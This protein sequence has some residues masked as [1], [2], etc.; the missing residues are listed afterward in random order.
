MLALVA[1]L[2]LMPSV[3]SAH[4]PIIIDDS[5]TTPE[6]GPL[7]LDGTISF[8]LYGVLGGG[9]DTRGFRVRLREGDRLTVELLVPNLA[10]ETE[11]SDAE[12]P[13]VLIGAPDGTTWT[14]APDMR[15]VFDEPFSRTSYLRLAT[16][17]EEAVAGDYE[18]TV[19]G[20]EP[21]RFTVAVGT[22]ERF[23]TP[24]ENV[25]DRSAGVPAVVEWYS[26]APGGDDAPEQTTVPDPPEPDD[27]S[28]PGTSDTGG[29]GPPAGIGIGAV[30]LAVVLAVVGFTRLRRR[31][32]SSPA[33][34]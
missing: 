27:S 3:A 25:I 26:T 12:L 11:L 8:A 14:L 15:V 22:L 30:V 17:G 4:D 1:P 32:E 10:P 19:T 6:S 5:Q 21:A 24:V 31:R 20:T 7:L 2:A 28:S 13:R 9:G 16:F 34:G 29:T 23:G 33:G 18:V